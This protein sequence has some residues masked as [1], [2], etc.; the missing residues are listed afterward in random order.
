MVE[1]AVKNGKSEKAMWKAVEVADCLLIKLQDEHPD[2]Y[3]MYMRKMNE[4]INGCHYQEDIAKKDVE[5]MY[6]TGEDGKSY[7]GAHWSADDV[8]AATYDKSFPQGTTRWDKYVAYNAAW[9]DFS[10]KFDDNQVLDIAYMFFFKDEDYD[11]EG[12]IWKYMSTK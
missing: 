4:A 8:E 2:E 3:A 12:K 1:S 6:H 9:H 5:A 7:T 11:G 10:N